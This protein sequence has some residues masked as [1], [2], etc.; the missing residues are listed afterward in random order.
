MQSLFHVKFRDFI[1]FNAKV[2]FPVKFRN[3][4]ML[5]VKVC[6]HVKFRNFIMLDAN[7]CSMSNLTLGFKFCLVILQV[8]CTIPR[9]DGTLASFV[10]FRV[11]HDN[12]RGPMKGG[13]RYHPE[14]CMCVLIPIY[15]CSLSNFLLLKCLHSF[16]RTCP[17]CLEVLRT[18]L[19]IILV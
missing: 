17:P 6:F 7:V 13:I 14:V 4:I 2:C 12:A 11:Q 9:D 19:Y 8:E 18:I 1:M 3:F 5:N 16:P 15:T 10:G